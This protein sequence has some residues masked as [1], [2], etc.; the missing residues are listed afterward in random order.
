MTNLKDGKKGQRKLA[1][2]DKGG[3]KGRWCW[4]MDLFSRQKSI[5]NLFS[6][7]SISGGVPMTRKKSHSLP[8]DSWVIW[9]RRGMEWVLQKQL[10]PKHL[11]R[12]EWFSHCR[13]TRKHR[14]IPRSRSRT[15]FGLTPTQPYP[16]SA[17]LGKESFARVTSIFRKASRKK[18]KKERNSI[19]IKRANFLRYG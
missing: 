9:L 15:F 5:E 19:T 18:P 10:L 14:N 3:Y 6:Q 4:W 2:Q 7:C 12:W 17:I 1:E 13:A 8:L 16:Q 11:V